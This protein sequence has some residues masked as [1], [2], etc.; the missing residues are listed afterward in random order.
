MKA[1]RRGSRTRGKRQATGRRGL[2]AAKLDALIEEAT[3]DAYDESE[4]AYGFLTMI[5]DNLAVPIDTEVFGVTVT[6]VAV[7]ITE[8]DE[9][10]A[11]CVRDGKGQRI[12]ILDLPLPSPPPKG[13]EWIEAYRRWAGGAASSGEDE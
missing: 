7:D 8:R 6:V 12:R 3:V 4:Q 9:I 10:V 13:H 5:Q 11:V 1:R 2:S